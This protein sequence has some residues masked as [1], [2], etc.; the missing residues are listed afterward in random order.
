M[1]VSRPGF[2]PKKYGNFGGFSKETWYSLMDK[3]LTY[4]L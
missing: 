2:L 1:P 3:L 4:Y